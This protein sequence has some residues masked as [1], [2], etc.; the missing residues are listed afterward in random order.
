[1]K[2][3]NTTTLLWEK[4]LPDMNMVTQ[5]ELYQAR[6]I[7][8]CATCVVRF[9]IKKFTRRIRFHRKHVRYI[10]VCSVV[11]D[12]SHIKY[13]LCQI[14]SVHTWYWQFYDHF[15]KI[16][17]LVDQLAEV[18][19]YFRYVYKQT[20]LAI[21]TLSWFASRQACWDFYDNY[22]YGILIILL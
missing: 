4:H 8:G 12:L 10:F 15:N 18:L 20:E 13:I 1:M 9:I 14:I 6:M 2:G 5:W 7:T 3:L 22:L 21:N 11:L 16:F 17:F 19:L